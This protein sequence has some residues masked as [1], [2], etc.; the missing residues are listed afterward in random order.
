MKLHIVGLPHTQT[1]KEHNACAF[2][3][4]I[5]NFIKMM[6]PLYECIHYG[7]EGSEPLC[8]NIDIISTKE[9]K[10]WG[11]YNEPNKLYK[12]DW[13]GK[14]NYWSEL[15]KRAAFKINKNSSKNHDLVCLI[16]GSMNAPLIT[17]LNSSVLPVEYAIGY[18]GTTT[19]YR[20]FPSYAHMHKIWGAE[21]GFDPNGKFYDTVI[22]HFLDKDD[23]VF[24]PN[25]QD[26]FVYLGRLIQRKG[27]HI[28]IETC[29][30]IG[31]K[32]VIAGSGCVDFRNNT[33]TCED[34]QTY[35]YDNMEYVGFADLKLRKQL[36]SEA[37]AVFMP[38]TYIEPFGLVA[39]EA[40]MSGT[41]VITTDWGAF[42][43]TVE[44]GKTGYRCRTL[45][46][47]V[48]AASSIESLDNNYIYQRAINNYSLEA[49]APRYNNYFQSLHDLWDKG[50][51]TI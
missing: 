6:S 23:F 25:K 41:P 14:A 50:W 47:F 17:Q 20:V 21:G 4:L 46:E 30:S 11:C 16:A 33:L 26:Y 5:Y 35:H 18:N 49:V 37:K 40:Q 44:Q 38:T 3:E 1:T 29:K 15:N 43:E 2:T 31:A 24:N 42:P 12:V 32:L 9:Q 19:N 27:I 51:Y 28:A 8:E 39:V 45:K 13:S 36:F 22:P 7:V 34:N 10:E 48:A